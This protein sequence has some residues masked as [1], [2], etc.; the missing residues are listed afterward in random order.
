MY[1]VSGTRPGTVYR[2]FHRTVQADPPTVEDFQS[3]K[4]K[5]WP[6]RGAEVDDPAL[7][8]GISVM[9][10]LE[11]ARKRARHFPQHGAFIA[12]LRIPPDAPITA[13]RTLRT[14]GHYTLHGAPSDLLACVAKV[15][16]VEPAKETGS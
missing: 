1:T 2:V 5:G 14:P 15:V 3:N 12:V 6:P 8:D 10:T 9:D 7:W 4:A 13:A 16:A 11:R